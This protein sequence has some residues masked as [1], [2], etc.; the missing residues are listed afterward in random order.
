[1]TPDTNTVHHDPE[2][3]RELRFWRFATIAILLALVGVVTLGAGSARAGDP[4][5]TLGE[6]VIWRHDGDTFIAAP[7][8]TIVAKQTRSG[9]IRM[10]ELD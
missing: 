9:F 3:R 5:V 8:G 10:V 7:E 6:I 1:M 4:V 2:L